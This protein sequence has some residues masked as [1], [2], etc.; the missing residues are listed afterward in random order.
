MSTEL[1]TK[2]LVL[3]KGN[4]KDAEKMHNNFLGEE[5]SAKYMLWKPTKTVKEAEEKIEKWKENRGILFFAYLKQTDE[6]IGFVSIKPDRAHPSVF[7]DIGICVG[8]KYTRKGYAKQ[9]LKAILEYSKTLGATK[10]EYSYMEGNIA[11]KKLAEA[12]GFKYS[13]KKRKVKANGEQYTEVFYE[14]NV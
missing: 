9:M 12:F 1:Q 10:F 7:G 11:S 3:K 14:H 6:P 8:S 2:D 4:I 5:E 13:H